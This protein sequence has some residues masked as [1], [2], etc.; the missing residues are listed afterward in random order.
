MMILLIIVLILPM[1]GIADENVT[2]ANITVISK[3]VDINKSSNQETVLIHIESSKTGHL[4]Y[5]ESYFYK[6]DTGAPELDR[7]AMHYN[8]TLVNNTLS[9]KIKRPL[10]KLGNPY[11]LIMATI[12]IDNNKEFE[13]WF[14]FTNNDDKKSPGFEIIA[15]MTSII[16][17]ICLSK[18]KNI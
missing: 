13:A 1:I 6:N 18:K 14:K 7:A 10:D 5:I 12:F 4:N 8:D 15:V 3:S 17:A 11:R 2:K 16:F 9:L